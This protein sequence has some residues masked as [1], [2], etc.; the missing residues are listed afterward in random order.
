MTRSI[1]PEPPDELKAL[2]TALCDRLRDEYAETGFLPFARF[3][4]R[5]LYEPGLGYYS[6]GLH[7]F[8]AAGDFV[9]APE[10]GGLFA[11]CLAAQ[12]SEAGAL[13]G[14]YDILEPG[15]GS[16][17]LAA[18]LL[19]ALPE[20]ALP[21]HYFILERSADLR[22]EQRR[23]L[24]E[25]AP[26]RCGRVEWLDAPPEDAWR[27]VL[28]ANEVIDALAV[29]R[30][31]RVDGQIQQVG[32]QPAGESGADG[33]GWD[34]R[35]APE[36]LSQ[37]VAQLDSDLPEPYES[38]ILPELADWLRAVTERMSSG[39]ALFIDYGYP[40]SEYYL[41]ERRTGTLM[42]HYRHRAHTDPF[43]WPGLQDL[44]AFVDFTALAE[45]GEACGLNLAGYTSQTL[46][47]LGCG[48]DRILAEHI[49]DTDDG[50]LK[51]NAEARQLTL[52]GM[53]GERF[54]VMALE[55]D[56]EHR[57]DQP[58]SGFS[59]RDLSYRL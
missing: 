37:A 16:G 23:T 28:I 57:L 30:F 35:P 47:L 40:R 50:G 2:S 13:L 22:A 6:A 3:M 1:L 51:L 38:E 15:A 5:A 43:F 55:R 41:P 48:L 33:F 29:E 12:V 19:N 56:L 20:A 34:Y 25:R 46:F 27:G 45:A 9:T 52:P 4:E 59:L 44:T 14:R 36:R 7:K 39:L 49:E 21:D 24:D 26:G 32:V 18:D 31:R 17:K 42:C 8:G 58:W 10:I 11:A 54:Q 53:M